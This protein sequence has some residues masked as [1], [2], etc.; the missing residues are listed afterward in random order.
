MSNKIIT[1][2]LIQCIRTMESTLVTEVNDS[3]RM[4][5]REYAEWV[6]ELDRKM[7]RQDKVDEI[8]RL[9]VE[10]ADYERQAARYQHA[11]MNGID[12][13]NFFTGLPMGM[14]EMLKF[15]SQKL[16]SID[17]IKAE[18]HTLKTELGK[19]DSRD[20]YKEVVDK[21]TTVSSK[22]EALLSIQAERKLTATERRQLNRLLRKSES[23]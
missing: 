14:A 1:E 5:G 19:D 3:N 18:I 13:P 22:I 8:L 17:A 20:G 12:L 11:L 10:L 4:T 6:R 9:E 16:E 23:Q 2:Q 7:D 21:V 15:N